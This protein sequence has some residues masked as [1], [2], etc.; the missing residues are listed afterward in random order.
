MKKKH[1][2]IPYRSPSQHFPGG[3]TKEVLLCQISAFIQFY[4]ISRLSKELNLE[5]KDVDPGRL[6]TSYGLDS[7]KAFELT[8]ELA[9]WVGH[10][11]PATLLWNYPTVTAL[12]QHLAEKALEW[13]DNSNLE[14]EFGNWLK[15]LAAIEK[16]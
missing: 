12:S 11:L 9:D 8:G 14:N 15:E 13:G 7:L 10:A 3:E 4:I 5:T 6:F 1:H 2:T 16:L